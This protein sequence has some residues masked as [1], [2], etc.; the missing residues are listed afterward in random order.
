MPPRNNIGQILPHESDGV[1]RRVA[2]SRTRG[3]LQKE[4]GMKLRF[5]TA[6][7][8]QTDE[9]GERKLLRPELVQI[10]ADKIKLT[11]E[12]LHTAQSRQKSYA[13]RRRRDLEFQVGDYVFLESITLERSFPFWKKR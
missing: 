11:R 5:S 10:T 6:F 1:T 13:D 9:V 3:G 2:G 12:H 7:H 4:Y 8:P